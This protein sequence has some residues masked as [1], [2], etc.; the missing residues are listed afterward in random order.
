V[1]SNPS[2][3]GT[4]ARPHATARCVQFLTPR[5]RRSV[6][7]QRSSRAVDTLVVRTP[8]SSHAIAA[9]APACSYSSLT[10]SPVV[11]GRS[12]RQGRKATHAR[13]L[14]ALV[15]PT[16]E[17]TERV[18]S[19]FAPRSLCL[20]CC[21]SWPAQWRWRCRSICCLPAAASS[22]HEQPGDEWHR[23]GIAASAQGSGALSLRGGRCKPTQPRARRGCR[24]HSQ[25][26]P[27]AHA[28]QRAKPV[29]PSI[30]FFA[31][32]DVTWTMRR[33]DGC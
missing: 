18:H 33:H 16:S 26:R 6:R 27:H 17:H 5:G 23:T 24:H 3:S 7:Q 28:C 29:W 9:P 30:V 10:G 22:P 2:V 31:V 11:H 12:G 13:P 19:S 1:N 4:G 32:A 20:A 15:H 25:V 8:R 14:S 21:L